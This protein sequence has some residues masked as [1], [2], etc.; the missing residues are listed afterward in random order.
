MHVSIGSLRSLLVVLAMVC[1]GCGPTIER[2]PFVQTDVTA[3]PEI[4]GFPEVRFWGDG[5][6]EILERETRELAAT[7]A[8]LA[9]EL[10][11]FNVLSISGG[12]DFGAFTAGILKAWTEHGDR[13]EFI[14]VTGV[15]TGALIA[16]FAFLGPEWD[17][18]IYT[19]YTSVDDEKL[20]KTRFLINI[21]EGLSVADPAPVREVLETFITPEFLELI[22]SEHRRGRRLWIGTSNLDARR[23]VVWDLGRI[24]MVG[25]PEARQL[26]IDAMIASASV[27]GVFPPVNVTSSLDGETFDELHVDG[28]L[29]QNVFSWPNVRVS[30]TLD[31]YPKLARLP[32]R[33]F[34]IVNNKLVSTPTPV[35]SSLLAIARS[36]ISTLIG[37][38]TQGN[39]YKIHWQSL[40]DDVDFNLAS[41]PA[42]FDATTDALFDPDLMRRLAELGYEMVME[43]RLWVDLPPGLVRP[44]PGSTVEKMMVA[45]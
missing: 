13:P 10:D 27:P 9:V 36:S 41:I 39:V 15:S 28:G 35:D 2:T 37:W 40:V 20:V 7:N 5:A 23:P 43:D 18:E 21:F 31:S 8:E 32:R 16:P 12:A 1:T 24:A 22:A 25:T 17:D 38:N 45:R 42:E 34:V 3:M 44:R 26:F 4:Q 33:L 29:T 6:P 14:L 30:D 19:T 11:G